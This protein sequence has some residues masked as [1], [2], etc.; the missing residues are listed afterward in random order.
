M[1]ITAEDLKA[2]GI[3]D[4]IIPEPIGGAHRDP[5]AM[6]RATSAI[7]ES[8]LADLSK[9]SGDELRQDRRQKYLAIG[10]QL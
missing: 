2:L 3:I 9:K 6:I 8:T 5:D 10:R 1:K 7:I 4:G